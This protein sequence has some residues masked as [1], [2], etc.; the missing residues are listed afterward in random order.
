MFRLANLET[1]SLFGEQVEHGKLSHTNLGLT[2]SPVLKG[3]TG[4]DA[5]QH[6]DLLQMRSTPC[7]SPF[8]AGDAVIHILVDTNVGSNW[9]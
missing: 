5:R 8:Q 4:I 3:L 7:L 1:V 2:A 9:M 6:F